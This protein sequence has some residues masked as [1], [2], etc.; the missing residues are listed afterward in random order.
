MAQAALSVRSDDLLARC[1]LVATANGRIFP[2]PGAL[3]ARMASGT[4]VKATAADR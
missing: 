4:T 2:L 1:L 3:N